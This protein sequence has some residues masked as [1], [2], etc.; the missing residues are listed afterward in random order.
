ME[1]NQDLFN[2][3]NFNGLNKYPEV[4]NKIKFKLLLEVINGAKDINR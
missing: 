2:K 4:K 3:F 1:E